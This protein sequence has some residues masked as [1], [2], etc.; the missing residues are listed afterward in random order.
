MY[1]RQIEDDNIGLRARRGEVRVETHEGTVF[2]IPGVENPGIEELDV[3]DLII[4]VGTWDA[5]E[6]VFSARAVTL[7]PRWPSHLRFLRG[8]VTGIEGRT[9]VLHALQGEVA[10][11]IDGDTIFR[12]PGV[13][14]PGLDDLEVGDKVGILVVRTAD[15]GLLAKVVLVRRNTDSLTDAIMAPVEAAT[16]L[17]ESLAQQAGIN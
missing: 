16:M 6:E 14:E 9:M 10:V 1:K 17:L 12:I 3:R 8:E 5:E 4:V 2:R 13:E 7:I 11:L 15:G